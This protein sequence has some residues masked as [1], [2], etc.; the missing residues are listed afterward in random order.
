MTLVALDPDAVQKLINGL[1]SY[2]DRAESERKSIVSCRDRQGWSVSLLYVPA[3]VTN[4]L[5]VLDSRI[6]EL[7]KRLAA[8]K[9]ANEGGITSKTPDGWIQYYIPDGE[10]DTVDNATKYNQVDKVNKARQDAADLKN[11]S[12]SRSAD[13]VYQAMAAHEGD[14]VYAAAFCKAYGVANMLETPADSDSDAA[15]RRKMLWRFSRI[16]KDASESAAYSLSTDIDQAVRASSSGPRATV[17]DAIL[18]ASNPADGAHTV[19]G[20]DFLIDLAEKVEDIEPG[21]E[22]SFDPYTGEGNQ[23]RINPGVLAGYTKDP[24]AAVLHAMGYNPEAA[25]DY[26]APPDPETLTMDGSQERD[27]QWAPSNKALKRLEMLRSRAWGPVA[28]NGLTAVFAAA[29]SQRA[30]PDP[31]S[32][33]VRALGNDRDERASWATGQGLKIIAKQDFPTNKDAAG[34]IG[35]LLGNCGQEIIALVAGEKLMT[36]E[37]NPASPVPLVPNGEDYAEVRYSLAELFYKASDSPDAAP[38]VVQGVTTYTV[39]SATN[40]SDPEPNDRLK[41]IARRYDRAADVLKLMDDIDKDNTALRQRYNGALAATQAL[42]TVPVAGTAFALLNAGLTLSGEP[43]PDSAINLND[44]PNG[45]EG[46]IA[47]FMTNMIHANLVDP[48]EGEPFYHPDSQ[49]ISIENKDKLEAFRTWA[50]GIYTVGGSR[51]PDDVAQTMSKL[52]SSPTVN[53]YTSA[54]TFKNYYGGEDW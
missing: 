16:W 48:P 54:N 26:L 24:L 3:T 31:A 30:V 25:L 4:A 20:K 2:R 8:A 9:A 23:I 47:A 36:D 46:L 6:E 43:Q 50:S 1:N 27:D 11:G 44:F 10:N 18:T 34:N 32:G 41:K 7:K 29:S 45:P 12:S 5:S 17:M 52:G 13:Q 28:M 38:K 40:I 19:F 21:L 49:V 37:S 51:V 14:P 22:T 33:T 15:S 53:K 35:V 42:S 39:S